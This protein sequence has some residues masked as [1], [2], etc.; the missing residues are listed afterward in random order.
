M[1]ELR[2]DDMNGFR[3]VVT[4]EDDAAA[5]FA[6]VMGDVLLG[7]L[8]VRKVISNSSEG[9]RSE[10]VSQLWE[11]WVEMYLESPGGS[12]KVSLKLGIREDQSGVCER[13][14]GERVFDKGVS[15]FKVFGGSTSTFLEAEIESEFNSRA[16]CGSKGSTRTPFSSNSC[17]AFIWL[18]VTGMASLYCGEGVCGSPVSA[19]DELD[20]CVPLS[21]NT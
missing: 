14:D 18:L 7:P 17:L 19:E 2:R 10:Q 20:S 21:P 15:A 11:S 9:N 4:V 5:G 6:A 12:I 1:L 13:L 3:A 16:K 8:S